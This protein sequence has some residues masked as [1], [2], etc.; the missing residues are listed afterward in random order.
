MLSP[1]LQALLIG[2]LSWRRLGRSIA[3]VYIVVTVYIFFRADSMIFLPPPPSYRDGPEVLKVPVNDRETISAIYL[4][5]KS[6]QQTD[7]SSKNA[8]TTILYIHGN[9]S[10]LGQIRPWLFQLH[11]WGYR[12]FAY[13]Y[14]GYGTSDGTPSETNA[15]EDAEAAYQYLTQI[16]KVAPQDILV[17]G[18]SLG[19][20][21]ATELARRH[22][23]GGVILES[24]FTSAF[25]VVLP[26][27]VFPFDKFP[28]R[29]KLAQVRS[30]ILVIHG[31]NDRTIAWSHGQELYAAAPGIKRS[32]WIA[33]ADHDDLSE[34]AGDRLRQSLDEFAALVATNATP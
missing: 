8:Q 31:Q 17:Y 6:L 1:K 3:F 24:T 34:V 9:A 27:P 11:N 32:L 16:L 2:E 12:V 19:G 5:Q 20:G 15:Y 22:P 4:P 21:S 33:G 29:N 10:D 26:I 14:R 23:V 7:R 30:P 13:D 25:R 28:N 18:K